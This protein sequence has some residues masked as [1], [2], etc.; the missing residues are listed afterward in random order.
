MRTFSICIGLVIAVLG[1][2]V[3]S[4]AKPTAE[5]QRLVATVVTDRGPI[6]IELLPDVAPKAVENFR[7]LAQRGYYN[8]LT[9]HRVVK[10]FMIQG[11]DPNGNGTGGLS[12]WGGEFADEIERHSPLY[13]TGYKRGAVAMAN[14]GPNTNRSQFFIVQ[15][16][17][18]LPPSYTIFGTVVRGMEVVD[19]I[20]D[21]PTTIGLD[22][23]KS[24][25]VNPPIIKTVSVRAEQPAT[26]KS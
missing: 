16:D 8:G 4:C 26:D 5:S 7:L 25:P 2:T 20:T 1:G 11:G 13:Q 12:A 15:K 6:V 23:M 14:N 17:Y 22:G 9:F 3:A 21:L 10:G 19:A 18:I 24:R